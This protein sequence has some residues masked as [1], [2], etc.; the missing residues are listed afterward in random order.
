MREAGDLGNRSLGK[1]SVGKRA[2]H[3]T[4]HRSGQ[5]AV[6]EGNHRQRSKCSAYFRPPGCPRALPGVRASP[7]PREDRAPDLADRPQRR[8]QSAH[9]RRA[10]IDG[11]GD[12]RVIVGKLSPSRLRQ[13]VL[14]HTGAARP[15]V[16]LGPEIGRRCGRHR[17]RRRSVRHRL[18][19]YYGL[20]YRRGPP[21][22]PRRRQRRGRH[23]RQP[24]RPA[25]GAAVAAPGQ[26][27]RRAG[28]GDGGNLRT[29]ARAGH[30]GAGRPYGSDV[31][32]RRRRRHRHVHRAGAPG[33]VRAVGRREARGHPA[34]RA[35]RRAWKERA[36]WPATTLLGW[37]PCLP[38]PSSG[39]RRLWTS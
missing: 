38:K 4:G 3:E 26:R 16:L 24:R 32:G 18:R 8:R 14:A 39:P 30:R 28:P 1:R 19:P 35:L 15:D 31:P 23:G 25:S 11:N 6:G 37:R 20:F 13:A 9:D 5:K 33:Q 27:G 10:D 36:F 29:A 34:A 12:E 17:F 2:P 21:C 22:S 7:A